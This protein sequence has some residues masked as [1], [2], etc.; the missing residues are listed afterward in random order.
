M[1]TLGIAQFHE[2]YQFEIVKPEFRQSSVE[3]SQICKRRGN[4]SKISS[5]SASV[6]LED[7]AAQPGAPVEIAGDNSVT[8]GYNWSAWTLLA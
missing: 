6:A 1:V 3:V 5:W 8:N 4:D 2:T 7:R